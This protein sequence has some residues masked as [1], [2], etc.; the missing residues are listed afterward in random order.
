MERD[1]R[2]QYGMSRKWNAVASYALTYSILPKEGIPHVILY[3][4]RSGS[5][6]P[7]GKR[8]IKEDMLTL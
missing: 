8:A 6:P 7:K 2:S 4:I 1:T 3:C 5:W